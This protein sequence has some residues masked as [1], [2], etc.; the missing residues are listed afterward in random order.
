MQIQ[1]EIKGEA[2]FASSPIWANPATDYD[3][4]PSAMEAARHGAGSFGRRGIASPSPPGSKILDDPAFASKFYASLDRRLPYADAEAICVPS[5]N[6]FSSLLT[7]DES[8]QASEV[9]RLVATLREAASSANPEVTK[10]LRSHL[11]V[12]SRWANECPFECIREGFSTF[13][14]QLRNENSSLL[15]SIPPT[16]PSPS[17]FIPRS[18]FVPINTKEETVSQIFRE[19]FLDTGRVP[20]MIQAMCWF[21]KYYDRFNITYDA[22]MYEEGQLP[23]TWR[24]FIAILAASQFD[25]LY[26]VRLEETEFLKSGGDPK[27]LL[28]LE[29]VPKRLTNLLQF[30]NIIAHQPWRLSKDIVASLLRGGADSW[31]QV[32]LVHAILIIT[33]FTS[34]A[35]FVFGCGIA[36]ELEADQQVYEDAF[37]PQESDASAATEQMLQILSSKRMEDDEGS[38]EKRRNFET[39][40]GVEEVISSDK[41]CFGENFADLARFRGPW[42]MKHVD[43]DVRSTSYSILRQQDYSWKEH[44]YSFIGG[45][46]SSV[47]EALDEEFQHIYNMTENTFNAA[48]NVNTQPF[49]QSIWYYVLRLKGI[50]HDDFNYRAVNTFMNKNLKVYVKKLA[51]APQTVTKYDFKDIGLNLRKEERAHIALLVIEARKQADILYACCALMKFMKG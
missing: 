3:S 16:A 31:S 41:I 36:P 51:C 25:C 9:T 34:L 1:R 20:H 5:D 37:T 7:P 18:A 4:L 50:F 40:A 13:I 48:Q 6:F 19:V 35:G 15:A 14:Q 8:V 12:V 33:T 10:Y 47:A 42:N 26:L 44:G 45:F 21:P 29:N 43:F 39:A 32:E 27:W 11:R 30:I 46:F 49:R 2:F 23:Q 28:G 38:E 22:I 24:H 17:Y